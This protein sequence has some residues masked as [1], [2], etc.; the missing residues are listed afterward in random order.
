[1]NHSVVPIWFF[2]VP[3][4]SGLYWC[5]K[6]Q[7]ISIVYIKTTPVINH[8][9][10]VRGFMNIHADLSGCAGTTMDN[11]DSAYGW[12]NSTYF[13]RLANIV[14]SPTTA[15][16]VFHGLWSVQ[17]KHSLYQKRVHNGEKKWK[18]CRLYTTYFRYRFTALP[19]A[20]AF[21]SQTGS[22]LEVQ[23]RNEKFESYEKPEEENSVWIYLLNSQYSFF[24]SW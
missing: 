20:F 12:V 11:P 6:N 19:R 16:N 5:S 17:N 23:V 1:M 24:F 8:I 3:L 22:F 7:T 14:K 10:Q 2:N 9:F 21:W 13:V 18:K 4:N 15:T